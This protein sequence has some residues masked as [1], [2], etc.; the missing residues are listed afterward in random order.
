MEKSSIGR[1]LGCVAILPAAFIGLV[2]L[3][4]GIGPTGWRGFA[5][6]FG[7]I[8]ICTSA[9]YCVGSLLTAL[10]DL[11]GRQGRAV[12]AGDHEP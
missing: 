3:T 10:S 5:E 8:A 7:W 1:G 11:C 6:L 2:G 12:I 4:D 9:S